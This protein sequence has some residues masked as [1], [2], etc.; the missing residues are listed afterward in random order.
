MTAAERLNEIDAAIEAI[1][2]RYS[3][4]ARGPAPE[5]H[6]GGGYWAKEC[7]EEMSRDPEITRLYRERAAVS[8]PIAGMC[9][10]AGI[11]F[12]ATQAGLFRVENGRDLFFVELDWTN[13]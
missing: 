10:H 2:N 9:S 8:A 11:M 7:G 1:R 4:K 5:G 6:R 3:A 12:L 13:A